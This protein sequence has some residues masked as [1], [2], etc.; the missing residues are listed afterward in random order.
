[1]PAAGGD[2]L[3]GRL[4][5]ACA[6]DWDRYT[7]HRFVAGLQTGALPEA[8][9]RY[10]LQ[11]DY[12][13]LIQFA[14]AHALAVYKA[15]TIADMRHGLDGLKAVLDVEI[16]LHINYCA[17]W[18]LSEAEMAAVPEDP[19][20]IAYT[21]YV[22]ERGLAGDLLDLHVAL[23]PCLQGY[24]E[25][26]RRLKDDPATRWDGNPYRDW[27]DM[28]AGDDYGAVAQAQAEILD[29]LLAARAGPGRFDALVATFAAAT[30]LEIDFWQMGL[31]AADGGAGRGA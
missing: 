9:F 21:R 3:V 13:F 15:D 23:A 20:N 10:Y 16:A 8:A 2:S 29:R 31:D 14:R 27:I 18:G 11:Q 26:G 25:I 4:T 12:L 28:Y 19:K 30:R 24:G 6:A 22:L 1:M 5:A 17:A 7:R